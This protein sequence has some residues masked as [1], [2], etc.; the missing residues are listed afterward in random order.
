MHSLSQLFHEYRR[1]RGGRREGAYREEG[2][3]VGGGGRGEREK[4]REMERRSR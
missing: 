2:G 1:K 3:G 4:E